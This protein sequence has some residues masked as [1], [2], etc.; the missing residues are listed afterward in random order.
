M[1][2]FKIL[3]VDDFAPF[4]RSVRSDLERT[5]DFQTIWEAANGLEAIQKARELQPDLILLDIS[6]PELDGIAAAREIRKLAPGAKI[7][8]LTENTAQE[9][10]E[11]ALATGAS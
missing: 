1:P 4:R 3:V 9:I 11:A 2:H 7:L 6:M 8:F 10:V 5:L